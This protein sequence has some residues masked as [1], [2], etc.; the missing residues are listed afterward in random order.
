M[1]F[2]TFVAFLS[3]FSN[4]LNIICRILVLRGYT[5]DFNFFAWWG[6]HKKFVA[7]LGLPGRDSQ[8]NK[9]RG[10]ARDGFNFLRTGIYDRSSGYIVGRV[11]NGFWWS[12]TAGSATDGHYLSMSPTHVNPQNN[13]Y[14]GHGFAVR[15]VVREG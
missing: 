3:I 13:N 2:T 6:S 9:I 14:R 11:T 4:F 1:D 5:G 12:T 10:R 7:I 8:F 15:C